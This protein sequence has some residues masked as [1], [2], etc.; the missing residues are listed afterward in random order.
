M[1][2][3]PIILIVDNEEE[4][5]ELL[6]KILKEEDYTVLTAANSK[7]AL[8]LVET[9]RPNLVI[10]NLNTSDMNEIKTLRRIKNIDENIEVLIITDYGTMKAAR[11][12]MELGAYDYV[13]KPF[14]NDYIM[15]LIKNVFSPVPGELLQLELK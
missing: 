9:E 3:K 1:N 6:C 15:A 13:T 8:E 10:M 12:A 11:T 2:G 7:E 14:D 4:S 5:L